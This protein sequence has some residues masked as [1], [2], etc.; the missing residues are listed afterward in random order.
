LLEDPYILPAFLVRDSL[1]EGFSPPVGASAEAVLYALALHLIPRVRRSEH[2]AL[3]LVCLARPLDLSACACCVRAA[4]GDR[5]TVEPTS[6]ARWHVRFAVP[7]AARASILIPFRDRPELLTRGLESLFRCTEPERFELLLLDNGSEQADTA[8]LLATWRA[9]RA[10]VRVLSLPGPFNFAALNN[11]GAALATGTH[12]LLLNNDT[13]CIAPGWLDELLGLASQPQI[14]A[15]GCTLLYA[16]RTLQHAGVWLGVAGLAA[17]AYLGAP[18]DHPG[19]ASEARGVRNV[20][21]VTGACLMVERKK[22]QAVGGMNDRELRVAFNDLDLCLRLEAQ[23][24]RTVITP[25]S[26]LIHHE[27]KSRG[28][29]VDMDEE[30]AFMRLHGPRIAKDPFVNVN[31]SRL[32]ADG[33]WR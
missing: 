30:R 1:L 21:A 29:R 28:S 18:A 11:K 2:I 12:L 26:A 25:H 20:S 3:P 6:D 32:V 22:W 10:N 14:G 33:R 27:S 24:F 23:G 15:V 7:A 17:H 9:A 19:H 13:E 4:L 8:E 16:D 31:F 5:A